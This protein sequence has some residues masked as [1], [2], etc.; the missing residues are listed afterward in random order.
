MCS[1]TGL[2]I[3]SEERELPEVQA[4][5]ACAEIVVCDNKFIKDRLGITLEGPSKVEWSKEVL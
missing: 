3:R 5:I 2:I 1:F 4:A